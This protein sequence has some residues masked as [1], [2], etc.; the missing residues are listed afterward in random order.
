MY[1]DEKYI[2]ML[3]G[4]HKEM[5]LWNTLGDVVDDSGWTAAL[6]EAEVAS[7][8]VA[9]CFF[10]KTA[11]LPRITHAHQITVLTLKRL[12]H[13]A[14]WQSAA[15]SNT[16]ATREKAMCK[17]SPT[18]MYWDFKKPLFLYSSR[19]IERRTSLC[20]LKSWGN[21][22]ICFLPWIMLTVQVGCQSTFMITRNNQGGV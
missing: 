3:G 8:G 2:G 17:R 22:Y 15:V 7:S 18:F 19:L 6:T 12:Q 13:E 11:H 9:G 14:F 5:A 4:L 21:R 10:F 16:E 20:L 1:G